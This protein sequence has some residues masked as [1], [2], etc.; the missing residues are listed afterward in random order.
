MFTSSPLEPVK[1]THYVARDIEA[2]GRVKSD[3]TTG[4]LSWVSRWALSHHG[5]FT[6]GRGARKGGQSGCSVRS[7]IVGLED[8][9]SGHEQGV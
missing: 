1:M 2:A 8:G 3:L 7:D 6:S 5:C 9:G 4:R